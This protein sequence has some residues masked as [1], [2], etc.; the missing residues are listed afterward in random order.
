M[1]KV[2]QYKD[3]LLNSF[4]LDTDNKTVRHKED[5]YYNRYVKGD[6]VKSFK[7][8]RL[9]VLGVHIP[10]TRCTVPLAHLVL[11]LK[12]ITIP[13]DKVV[14]HIDGNV[15]NNHIDNLR[16]VSQVI[17]CRN[18]TRRNRISNTGYNGIR[19]TKY[20]TYTVRVTIN[21]TRLYLGTA[22]TLSEA[23]ELRDRYSE[24]RKQD[25]Y[26]ERHYK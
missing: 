23:I 17:N 24:L 3:I 7:T 25:G 22:K 8:H 19:L 10:K 2:N 14:D 20:G 15:K 11:L 13:D 6:E 5:G 9:G 21:E 26:T 4:Y 18:Q 12:G 16:V 1:L